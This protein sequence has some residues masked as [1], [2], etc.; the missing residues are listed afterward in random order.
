MSTITKEIQARVPKR[1]LKF[2]LFVIIVIMTSSCFYVNIRSIPVHRN[3]TNAPCFLKKRDDLL[4]KME[5]RIN[6]LA[7]NIFFV[8]K[9]CEGFTARFSCAVEAA[10][11]ANPE[12]QINV[13]FIGPAYDVR[14]LVTMQTQFPNVKFLR[15]RPEMFAKSSDLSFILNAKTLRARRILKTGTLDV[16]KYWILSQYGGIYLDKSMIVVGPLAKYGNNWVVRRNRYSFA[17]E[18]IGLVD[19]FAGDRFFKTISL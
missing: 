1:K 10:A 9:D 2:V 18:P 19:D 4:P 7:R 5:M 3:I 14:H 11:A 15:I 12:M 16:L 6:P 8:E 17:T 13:L